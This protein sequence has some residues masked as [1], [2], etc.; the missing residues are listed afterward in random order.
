[1]REHKHRFRAE[2]TVRKVCQCG[3]EGEP[4]EACGKWRDLAD[5]RSDVE[6]LYFCKECWAEMVE[7]VAGMPPLPSPVPTTAQSGEG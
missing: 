7:S 1:M 6:G 2:V 3:A 5:M 4:C